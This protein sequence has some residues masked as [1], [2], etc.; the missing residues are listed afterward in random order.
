MSQL[1]NKYRDQ[2]RLDGCFLLQQLGAV[3]KNHEKALFLNGDGG[4]WVP[5]NEF[6][7][8]TSGPWPAA[9][10]NWAIGNGT[11]KASQPV[12]AYQKKNIGTHAPPKNARVFMFLPPWNIGISEQP[13]M[14]SD[15]SRNVSQSNISKTPL[16]WKISDKNNFFLPTDNNL[17]LTG[18]LSFA[19]KLSSTSSEVGC[20]SKVSCEKEQSLTSNIAQYLQLNQVDQRHPKCAC[21]CGPVPYLTISTHS[22]TP[23][24]WHKN[25]PNNTLWKNQKIAINRNHQKHHLD[26][27]LEDLERISIAMFCFH[28]I[29]SK[30]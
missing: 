26:E 20:C 11:F 24:H 21:N 28:Q 15:S 30:N 4:E 29:G 22:W 8:D 19:S 7:G 9:T 14:S 5:Q 23:L 17:V 10:S 3:W 12:L 18:F 16:A 13:A 25:L 27:H 2:D 6:A 1:R